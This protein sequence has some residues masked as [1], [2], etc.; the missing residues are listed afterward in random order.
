MPQDSGEVCYA[1]TGEGTP[2]HPPVCDRHYVDLV[3]LIQQNE[4]YAV[5]HCGSAWIFPGRSSDDYTPMAQVLGRAGVH[6]TGL[7][8][9]NCLVLLPTDVAVQN[10]EYLKPTTVPQSM[11]DRTK[12]AEAHV[13][14][15]HRVVVED[16]VPTRWGV[17]PT[18]GFYCIAGTSRSGLSTGDPVLTACQINRR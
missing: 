6:V 1:T 13:L 14:H 3:D 2:A 5:F 4:I 16:N 12:A 18:V 15:P 9:A 17:R 7:V 11:H 8:F 10:L